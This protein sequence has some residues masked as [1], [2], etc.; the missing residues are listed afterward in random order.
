MGYVDRNLKNETLVL[1]VVATNGE[2]QP[3][4]LQKDRSGEGQA[5]PFLGVVECVLLQESDQP[6]QLQ[7]GRIAASL[8]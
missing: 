5:G 6:K 4:S 1:N 8:A 7:G 3:N 2:I